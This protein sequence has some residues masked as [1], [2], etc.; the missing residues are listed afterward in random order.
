MTANTPEHDTE[1]WWRRPRQRA[2]RRLVAGVAGGIAD[3]IEVD[4]LV[5]RVA[6]VVLLAAGGLGGF[7]YLALWAFLAVVHRG[8]PRAPGPP[9]S[10]VD[11]EPERLAAVALITTGLLLL[12]RSLELGFV[13]SL[14]WP[15]AVLG[16]GLLITVTRTG[17]D[18]AKLSGISGGTQKR[19]VVFARIAAGIVL[20]L[21][22]F[23]AFLA[24]N[25]DVGAA[26]D[27]GLAAIVI[28]GGVTLVLG[29]WLWRS[30]G[31]LTEER[32]RRIRSEER[33]EL[34]AQLHDSVLQ[35]LALIQRNSDDPA[36]MA[37]LARGQERELRSWLYGGG[38]VGRSD[39]LSSGLETAAADVELHH[40]VPIEVVV[41]GDVLADDR[42][43]GLL[44]ASREAM[45]NASR[46]SGSD[47]IDVFAEVTDGEVQVFV[48]DTGI[49]FDVDDIGPDRRGVADSIVARLDRLGGSAEIRSAPGEGTEVELILPSRDLRT[50]KP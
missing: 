39:R 25:L 18:I 31:E 5:I 9:R 24:L 36:V 15:V 17:V 13:D 42:V 34:A 8:A 50:E 1:R 6:F 28:A 14:V 44:A 7:L 40:R 21:G 37:Q 23:I 10:E 16:L 11:T 4:A 3:E 46:H 19:R 2:E 29:P 33:S 22:G 27:V 49:G 12:F 47:K 38:P 26:R 45:L 20:A 32:R 43:G 48:R 41:V 35:T 30:V